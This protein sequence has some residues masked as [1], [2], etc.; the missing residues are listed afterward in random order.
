MTA[1]QL[2]EPPDQR[3]RIGGHILLRDVHLWR[4]RPLL[5]SDRV[6]AGP[7]AT[8]MIETKFA[9]ILLQTTR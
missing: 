4:D 5:R 1:H 8:S 2:R 3:F 9:L 7:K 6:V